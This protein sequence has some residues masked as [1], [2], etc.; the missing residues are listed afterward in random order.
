MTTK[1]LGLP[2]S[3]VNCEKQVLVEVGDGNRILLLGVGVK[4][5]QVSKKRNCLLGALGVK[6]CGTGWHINDTGNQFNKKS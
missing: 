2:G 6:T 3:E 4:V 5:P 1:N